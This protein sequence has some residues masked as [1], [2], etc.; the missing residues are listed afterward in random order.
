HDQQNEALEELGFA[1]V[2]NPQDLT[3]LELKGRIALERFNFDAADHSV[4]LM[5]QVNPN[6]PGADLLEARNF[7]AQRKPREAELPLGRVL[8]DQP[9]NIEALGLLAASQSLQ[10]RDGG[11]QE[12]LKQVEK[13]DPHNASAYFEVAEQL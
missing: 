5:R 10:L 9:K 8:K 11:M 13:I 7:L 4:A 1:L 2:A 12:I 3:A 6:A